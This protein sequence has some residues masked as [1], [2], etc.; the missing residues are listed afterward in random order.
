VPAKPR[1][2][3]M[4]FLGCRRSKSAQYRH[5][6]TA[7]GMAEATVV[8]A[9]KPRYEWVAAP[10]FSITEGETPTHSVHYGAGC[11]GDSVTSSI[12]PSYINALPCTMQEQRNKAASVSKNSDGIL[13]PERLD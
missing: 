5:G 11:G 7:D 4:L 6:K 13:T 3:T 9:K 8:P 12:L 1:V 2:C 10:I